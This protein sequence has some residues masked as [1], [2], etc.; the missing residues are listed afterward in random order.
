MRIAYPPYDISME[1]EENHIYVLSVENTTAYS[2]ILRDIWLQAQGA[3]GN[4]IMSEGERIL[5]LSKVAICIFNPFDIN[6][7]E[8]KILN[9]V[10]QELKQ[11]SL[12]NL[13]EEHA[14]VNKS[15]LNYLEQVVQG[16]SYALDY[17]IDLDIMDLLKVYDVHIQ[18]EGETLLEN[19]VEYVRTVNQICKVSTVFAIGLKYYFNEK[20][21]KQ[22]YEFLFYEK[23]NL[24]IVESMHS[25]MISNEKCWILD[26]DL[27]LISPN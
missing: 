16:V 26:K 24:I 15:I 4:I 22:L 8:K 7:N 25:A 12:D 14:N 18:I 27:C 10:Y 17:N 5:N 23:I 6:C 20:E 19:L 2:A 9:K 11:V 21:L 13:V 3:E 1:I